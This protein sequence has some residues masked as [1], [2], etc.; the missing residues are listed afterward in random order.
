MLELLGDLASTAHTCDEEL[1]AEGWGTAW[2]DAL[3]TL[4]GLLDDPDPELREMVT[5]PLSGGGED[6]DRL[7]PCLRDRWA[8]EDNVAVL[9]SLMMAAER[10][11]SHCE[12][13]G[14]G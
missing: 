2:R 4:A 7:V 3:P 8:R 1:I 10:L 12:E 11:A 6:S 9:V 5:Y 13:E 14:V